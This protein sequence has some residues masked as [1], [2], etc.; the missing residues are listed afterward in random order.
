MSAPKHPDS[1]VDTIAT[2]V[3]DENM[4]TYQQKIK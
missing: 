4:A 2:S 3:A 1:V